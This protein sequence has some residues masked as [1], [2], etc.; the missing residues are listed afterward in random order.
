[1]DVTGDGMNHK[2][3]KSTVQAFLIYQMKSLIGHPRRRSNPAARES[4]K[5]FIIELFKQR[6]DCE[7]HFDSIFERWAT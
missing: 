2:L 4:E 5:W 7:V 6:T 3:Y 1:M